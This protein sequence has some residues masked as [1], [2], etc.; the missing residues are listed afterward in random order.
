MLNFLKKIEALNIY[1]PPTV[2]EI[3]SFAKKCK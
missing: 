2:S 3:I 1:M